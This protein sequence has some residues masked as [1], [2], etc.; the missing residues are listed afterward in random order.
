MR[1]SNQHKPKPHNQNQVHPPL[2]KK[3]RVDERGN[4]VRKLWLKDGKTTMPFVEGLTETGC[5]ALI[6]SI[7]STLIKLGQKALPNNKFLITR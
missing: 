7:N 2:P 6:S 4:D 1:T 3:K 5:K